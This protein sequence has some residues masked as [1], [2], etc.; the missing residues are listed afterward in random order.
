MGRA[1]T[2]LR[3][4]S[5]RANCELHSRTIHS[6][7]HVSAEPALIYPAPLLPPAGSSNACSM[8]RGA[9]APDRHS[10]CDGGPLCPCYRGLVVWLLLPICRHDREPPATL[11]MKKSHD[12][13]MLM[14]STPPRLADHAFVAVVARPRTHAFLVNRLAAAP[15]RASQ[16]PYLLRRSPQSNLRGWLSA[17]RPRTWRRP[18]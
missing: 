15:I 7:F 2:P 10:G 13:L 1:R 17:G 4:C 16:W 18:W 12:D 5:T 9:G 3:V 14:S 6:L 8:R 11:V